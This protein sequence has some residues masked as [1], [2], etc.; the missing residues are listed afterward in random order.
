MMKRKGRGRGKVGNEERKR[1]RRAAK[2][3]G[4]KRNIIPNTIQPLRE[5]IFYLRVI[6]CIES[7]LN[8]KLNI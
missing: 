8:E 6:N 2:T 7:L 5:K 1:R 4:E 3:G